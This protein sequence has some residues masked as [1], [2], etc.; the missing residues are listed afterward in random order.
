MEYIIRYVATF[1]LKYG[2]EC[3]RSYK[4]FAIA[5]REISKAYKRFQAP[6]KFYATIYEY[7]HPIGKVGVGLKKKLVFEMLK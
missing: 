2:D 1:P 7:K 5:K 3:V 4:S 6:L